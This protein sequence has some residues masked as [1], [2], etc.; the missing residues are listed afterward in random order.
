MKSS[1]A[2]KF[3]SGRNKYQFNLSMIVIGCIII[4]YILEIFRPDI[5]ANCM[6]NPHLIVSSHE[7]WRL[8][9][10]VFS[11]PFGTSL[12][13]IP[14]VGLVLIPFILYFYYRVGCLLES[15]WGTKRYN[16]FIAGGY[17]ITL[18]FVMGTYAL[19]RLLGYSI[20]S[21]VDPMHYVVLSMFLAFAYIS[22]DSVMLVYFV[23]PVKIRWVAII[24]LVF[25]AL[26][27]LFGG[28]LTK[29][30]IIAAVINFGIFFLVH[31]KTG[32]HTLARRNRFKRKVKEGERKFR[33]DPVRKVVH[34]YK[35]RCDICGRTDIDSPE[36]E[37]RYCSKCVGDHEYC[38]D[39]IF[40]HKHIEY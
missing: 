32:A 30:A 23:I 35:H 26:E 29:A 2:G 5:Y 16:F 9:T 17:F 10:W 8:V 6:M 22:P 15:V 14:Y 31:L 33:N 28:I 39:H 37:F 19:F 3:F 25:L 11:A 27:F 40:T 1:G 4:G 18:I 38:S 24:D 13:G 21:Y 20:T 34:L 12:F 36:L 7:Y